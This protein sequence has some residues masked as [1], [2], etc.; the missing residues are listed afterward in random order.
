MSVKLAIAPGTLIEGGGVLNKKL[1]SHFRLF[2]KSGVIIGE[3]YIL[4]KF[5]KELRPILSRNIYKLYFNCEC[6]APEIKR[7][8]NAA[9]KYKPGFIIGIGGGKAIDTAKAS[10]FYLNVPVITIPTSAATCAASSALSS[11]YYP[12][13]IASHYLLLDKSPEIVI[14]D[15]KLIASAPAYMFSSGMADALAK[16]YESF[17]YTGGRAKNI[18]ETT[19]LRTAETIYD[20]IFKIGTG[21]YRDLKRGIISDRFK[22]IVRINVVL[23]SLVG[24]IGG[25]GCRACV[26]HAVNNGF[27]RKPEMRKFL[28]GEIVGFGNLVQLILENKKKEL[29]KLTGLYKK[30]SL[31]YSLSC[32]GETFE[33]RELKKIIKYMCSPKET[34]KN[35]QGKVSEKDIAKALQTLL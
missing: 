33:K 6:S 16:Y 18:Y 14:I 11:I 10:A 5:S 3:K 15:Y 12:S 30:L 17:A 26:S 19:A 20:A 29:N 2:G 7:L 24:G 22:Q 9:M 27:T 21:A 34:V 25:E 4:D 35:M 31:P 23:A 28:H 13:G 1:L 8:T 32:F